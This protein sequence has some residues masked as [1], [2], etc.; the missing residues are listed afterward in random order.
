MEHEECC[1][2]ITK[3]ERIEQI[4]AHLMEK[5]HLPREQVMEMMPNFLVALASHMEKIERAVEVGDLA[6]IGRAGHTMKGALLNL[7]L[8][9]CVDIALEIEQRG[10]QLDTTADYQMLNDKLHKELKALLT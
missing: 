1:I 7:G 2:M 9:D 6:E 8:D 4:E 3:Q 10:K 5:F